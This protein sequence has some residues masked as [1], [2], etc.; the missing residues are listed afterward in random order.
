MYRNV[1]MVTVAIRQSDTEPSKLAP[2]NTVS[3][4]ETHLNTHSLQ[5]NT[6]HHLE[7]KTEVW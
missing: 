5:G 3:S 1:T 2:S 7:N 4:P 6:A